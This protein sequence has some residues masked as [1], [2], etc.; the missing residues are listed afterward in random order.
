M[1]EQQ[2]AP[3]RLSTPTPGSSS[4]DP[5]AWEDSIVTRKTLLQRLKNKEDQA[6]WQEFFDTYWNLI[7]RVA[8]KAGLSDADAQEIVQETVISVARKIDGFVYDPAVCSFKT[9]ML[10]LTRWRIL[11]QLERRHRDQELLRYSASVSAEAATKT[12]T[13]ERIP[14]PASVD[15]EATWDQEWARNLYQLALERAKQKV[16]PDQFQIFDCYVTQA[17]PAR[18]VAR[19]LGVNLARVYLAKHRMQKVLKAE[20]ARLQ[21]ELGEK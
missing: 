20:L 9:W 21:K 13:V 11:N 15:V 14:D 3:K 2:P 17:M 1:N 5:P 6:S 8:I 4:P 7:Y 12:A 18:Q 16:S 10:R 19:T